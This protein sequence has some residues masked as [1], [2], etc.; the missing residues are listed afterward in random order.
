MVE[1]AARLSISDLAKGLRGAVEP[2][3]TAVEAAIDS[4]M[5]ALR[6]LS[7]SEMYQ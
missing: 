6:E 5:V 2:G 3:A 7:L 1:E 4:V